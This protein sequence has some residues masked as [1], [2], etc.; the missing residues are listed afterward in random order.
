MQLTIQ[1]VPVICVDGPSG[2]GKGTLSL[3]LADSLGWHLL[4]S[5]V[6]YRVLGLACSQSAVA[7]DDAP[8]VAAMARSL[9]IRF[10]SGS[11]GVRVWLGDSDVTVAIRTE[12]GGRGASEVAVHVEVREALLHRQREL[13]R[14]PGLIADGRDMGT[15]VF[16][17]AS[18]KIFLTAS[19]EARAERRLLQLQGMGESVRL[20]RLLADIGQRDARDE[21]RAASPLVAAEDAIVVDSTTLTADA[22]MHLVRG[23][24]VSRGIIKE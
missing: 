12:A 24:A 3:Q 4:D 7:L 16:P 19:A 22:V 6:L 14:L 5:G 21:S 9:D 8:A 1:G 11:D 10:Q 18:L 20:A 13:A 17:D 15:V 2:V 23:L